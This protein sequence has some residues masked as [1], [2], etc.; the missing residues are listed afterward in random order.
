MN[1]K[2]NFEE[3]ERCRVLICDLC[4]KENISAQMFASV[5]S[6]LTA[7]MIIDLSIDKDVY[8][9]IVSETYDLTMRINENNKN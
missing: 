4:K 6:Y 2:E 9:H 8:M 3:F 1:D 5:S 7:S